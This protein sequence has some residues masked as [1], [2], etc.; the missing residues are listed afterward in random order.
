MTDLTTIV[1]GMLPDATAVAVA[2]ATIAITLAVISL[3]RRKA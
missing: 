2:M 3:I 1:T